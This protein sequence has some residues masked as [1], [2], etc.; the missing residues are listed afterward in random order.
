MVATSPY[1]YPHRIEELTEYEM[2]DPFCIYEVFE[3]DSNHSWF[4]VQRVDGPYYDPY[5]RTWAKGYD[6]TYKINYQWKKIIWAP[7]ENTANLLE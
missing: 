4:P 3:L 5:Y 6:P 1:G 2:I 7:D